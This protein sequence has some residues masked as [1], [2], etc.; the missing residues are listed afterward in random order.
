M[1]YS[2][3]VILLK[4]FTTT[5]LYKRLGC[6]RGTARR[7]ISWNIVSCC[8]TVKDVSL[9]RILHWLLYGKTRALLSS[10]SL[11]GPSFSSPSLSIPAFLA[12]P[13]HCRTLMVLPNKSSAVAEMGDRGHKRHRPKRGCAPLT[14]SPRLTQCGL[15][16]GLP[17]YQVA[18]W[19]IQPLGH[20]TP[21]SQ[22]GQTDRTDN[23]STGRT[24]LQTVAQKPNR[25][26]PCHVSRC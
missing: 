15:V 24:V 23:D 22:A 11:H 19:S 25:T 18:S 1:C 26:D 4:L 14:V 3:V 6:R 12:L 5:G 8:A 16:W 21:T 10:W 17:S 2:I 13:L 20:N 9:E 7:A